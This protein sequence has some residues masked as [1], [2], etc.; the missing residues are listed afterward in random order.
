M[1]SHRL[2]FAKLNLIRKASSLDNFPQY[3]IVVEGYMVFLNIPLNSA[4]PRHFGALDENKNETFFIFT[5]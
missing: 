3:L 2:S 4:N 5:Y 1:H